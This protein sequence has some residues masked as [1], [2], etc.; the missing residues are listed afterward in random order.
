MSIDK[1]KP[2]TP[3][4]IKLQALLAK[5]KASISAASVP[6]VQAVL[7][8]ATAN[9]VH[10]IDLSNLIP[11][12]ASEPEKEEALDNLISS[13]PS[14]PIAGGGAELRSSGALCWNQTQT[15][16]QVAK[17]VG[18]VF[19]GGDVESFELVQEVQQGS[20][21]LGVQRQ[22]EL[23]EKQ[24][25]GAD[26]IVSGESIVLIGKAGTG[27]TT[28]MRQTMT[29][30]IASGR[31]PQ[32]Q[33]ST[34]YLQVGLPGAAVLSYTNKAVNNIRHAMPPELK[35]HTL[36]IH[37]L[38]EFQPK[39]YELPDEATGQVKKTMRFEPARNGY[40]PLPASLKFIAIE[41]ASMC[42]TGLHALLLDALPHTVQMLY[43]GDI[44]QLP[45]VFDQAILGYKMLELPVVELTEVYRQALESPIL[46][47]A[48]TLDEGKLEEF[49]AGK[50]RTDPKT[51]KLVWDTLAKWNEKGEHGSLTIQPWQRETPPMEALGVMRLFFKTQWEAGVYNP[52]ED[53]ILCPIHK[54]ANDFGQ[55]L[56]SCHNLNASI[57]DFLSRERGDAVHEVIAGFAKHY[58]AEGDRVLYQKEDAI[59]TKIVRNGRYL[60]K[61]P[62][63]A[64]VHMNRYGVYDEDASGKAVK[65]ISTKTA[66]DITLEGLLGED[67]SFDED[68]AEAML[69]ALG[70]VGEDSRVNQSSHI[71]TVYC[72][73]TGVTAELTTAAEVNDLL[74]GYAMTVHKAQGSEWEKV[75]LILHHTHKIAL[76]RELVYTAMTRARKHLHIFTH[77]DGLAAACR[78]QRIKGNTI[79]EKAEF[80]KGKRDKA[81]MER[82]AAEERAKQQ[83]KIDA[84]KA[85]VQGRLEECM[86]KAKLA[87]PDNLHDLQV[88][89]LYLDCG[90][91]AGQAIFGNGKN[92]TM[93]ISPTYLRY[94]M[95]DALY[96]TI[97]HELAHLYANRWFGCKDHSKE[98]QD[99]AAVLGAKPSQFHDMPTAAAIRGASVNR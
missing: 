19:S 1:L 67:G 60:G 73:V 64:S 17:S 74:G 84:L 29:E 79:A 80:F 20:K 44:R 2:L 49:R 15:Q 33:A 71:I 54:E 23:N 45:P 98:W 42:G 58:W 90:N 41:E 39:Y 12:K 14:N 6:Q 78:N 25:Q 94:D 97:P 35:A 55:R 76:S 36:T 10:D 65:E 40:N 26:L 31:V 69:N 81:T 4:Q 9:G 47:C 21:Q 96:D 52:E 38:L 75:Y 51:K 87:F 37:K 95:D 77:P 62:K 16:T 92:C 32:M 18:A 3:A 66:E 72:A 5:A 11:K 34:Q 43:I 22:I 63:K 86:A 48:L 30:L 89:L 85:K 13:L 59:I 93:K 24:R 99:I 82:E 28:M 50:P 83:E 8:A 7:A 27:K 61:E 70:S 56:V 53:I 88:S 91:A 46:R 57:A 68:K